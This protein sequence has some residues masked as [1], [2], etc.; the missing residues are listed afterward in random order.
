MTIIGSAGLV[1]IGIILV[2]SLNT[3]IYGYIVIGV[4]FV[5]LIAYILY[6]RVNAHK[7]QQ[8]AIRAVINYDR[9][10]FGVTAPHSIQLERV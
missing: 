4:T 10:I 7:T 5:S 9:E 3:P 1:I 2:L 6:K 8:S